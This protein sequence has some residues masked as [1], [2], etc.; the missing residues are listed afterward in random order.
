[1]GINEYL[2]VLKALMFTGWFFMFVLV[3]LL[4]GF[5]FASRGSGVR[6]PQLH[7]SPCCESPLLAVTVRVITG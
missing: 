5:S 7:T 3:R 2:E 4:V 1:M 6:F